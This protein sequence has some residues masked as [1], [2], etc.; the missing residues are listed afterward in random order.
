[1]N[2]ILFF[3]YLKKLEKLLREIS[4]CR[5]KLEKISV[6]ICGINLLISF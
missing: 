3:L 6:K 1:M 2:L 4:K 5:K